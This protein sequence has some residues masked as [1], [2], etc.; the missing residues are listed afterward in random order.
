ME[1][2]GQKLSSLAK[3][4]S[5][6]IVTLMHDQKM[7]M[8]IPPDQSGWEEY[9]DKAC[10]GYENGEKQGSETVNGRSTEKWRCTGQTMVPEGETPADATV[11][12]DPKLKFGI[13]SVEDNGNIFEIRDFQVGAQNASMFEV[14]AGYKKFDMNAMMQQMQQ[15]QQ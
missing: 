10:M 2:Q 12:Y 7:Y 14:P 15:Q 11:W 5:D 4:D 3:W 1:S 9:E 13:R 8:E 6:V